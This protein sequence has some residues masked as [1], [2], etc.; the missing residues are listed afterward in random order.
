MSEAKDQNR[1][2]E[3]VLVSLLTK[4]DGALRAYARSV[5]PRW[6]L[7][8]EVMQEASIT[9]WQKRDQL[10]TT[11]GF[12][13]WS[14]VII[15]YKCLEALAELRRS[16]KVFSDGVIEQLM[17]EAESLDEDRSQAQRKCVRLCLDEFSAPHRELILAPFVSHGR[18]QELAS[19]QGKSANA[20]YKLLRRLRDKLGDCV[21]KRLTKEGYAYGA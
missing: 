14:R 2:S 5:L 3:E 4:H 1:P 8:D 18:I 19:E 11:D 6:D 20:L 21:K 15:R 13:P 7:V 10:M 16:Q 9:I 12:L 17:I